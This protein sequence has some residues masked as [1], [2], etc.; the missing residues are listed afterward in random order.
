MGHLAKGAL[1]LL[2]AFAGSQ[3]ISQEYEKLEVTKE[4]FYFAVMPFWVHQ[5][6]E[7]VINDDS[8]FGYRGVI[9]LPLN[10]HWH[11]E[12]QIADGNLE[13]GIGG[14]T[15]YYQSQLGLD[16]AYRFGDADGFR[17]FVLAG[18]GAVKDDVYPIRADRPQKDETS[19]FAN[20]G[21]GFISRGMTNAGLRIRLEA[22][23]VMSDFDAGFNDWQYGLGLEV[24]VGR[25]ETIT[26]VKT[27]TVVQRQTIAPQPIDSDRDG[28]VN[29]LDI[30][31]NTPYGAEVDSNGCIVAKQTIEL[32]DIQFE[33]GSAKLKFASF[34]AIEKLSSFMKS[35]RNVNV[36]LAGHT[37]STG[38]AKFN[39]TLSEQRANAVRSELIKEGIAPSR[40]KAVGYGESRPIADNKTSDGRLKNRRVEFEIDL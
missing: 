13:T 20:V 18:A 35:Q 11:L 29:R 12:G 5:D 14:F 28:V 9:G 40:I 10:E 3:A 27:K 22:R 1:A 36:T 25:T 15:D 2:L 32:K 26:K 8:G 30:C 24:P 33:S 6:D 37:D 7:R 17:P 16:I 4:Q 21:F 39:Q 31:P 19:P 38:S 23:Y 34:T